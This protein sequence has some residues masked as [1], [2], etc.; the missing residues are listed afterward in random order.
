MSDL[1]TK[2]IHIAPVNF[3][4]PDK[5]PVLKQSTFE[6][7]RYCRIL[8]LRKQPLVYVESFEYGNDR[9]GELN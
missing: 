5:H 9:D 1:T 6:C 3:H 7:N 4:C 8:H 2:P